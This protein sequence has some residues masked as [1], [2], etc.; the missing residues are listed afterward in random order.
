MKKL[1]MILTLTAAGVMLAA[2]SVKTDYAHSVNFSRYK[3][4]S[5]LKVEAGD[6][7]W[8]DR[9]RRDV[10]AELSAKGWR[11]VPSGGDASIAAV[12]SLKN[13]QRLET[14]YDDFGGG[15]YWQGFGDGLAT[16]TVENVPIGS[17]MVNIFDSK[18]K[19]LVW[20]ATEEN[21]VSGDPEKNAKNLQHIIGDMFKK[22]PP[23]SKD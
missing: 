18:T 12:G 22:F 16:T 8:Q 15:W 9:I 13:E 21:A 14:F 4:Y 6:S 17:L 10:D 11:N 7:L 1:L 19:K 3:T 2:A 23:M 5:W 20:R